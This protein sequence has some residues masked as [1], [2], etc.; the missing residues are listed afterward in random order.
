MNLIYELDNNNDINIHI[1]LSSIILAVQDS[2]VSPHALSSDI[3]LVVSPGSVLDAC[4]RSK[5]DIIPYGFNYKINNI[6]FKEIGFDIIKE[7]N[8]KTEKTN[9]NISIDFNYRDKINVLANK[10]YLLYEGDIKYF[11]GNPSKNKW[12]NENI[13]QTNTNYIEGITYIICKELGDTLQAYYAKLF[14]NENKLNNKLCLF[15]CDTVLALRCRLLKVPV[16][17]R[18]S[19][20]NS[21][22]LKYYPNKGNM[23][24]TM[25]LYECNKCINQNKSVITHINSVILLGTFY[26]NNVPYKVIDKFKLILEKIIKSIEIVNTIIDTLDTSYIDYNAYTKS[27]IQ[28]KAQHLFTLFDGKNYRLYNISALYP[29]LEKDIK[30]V[31]ILKNTGVN[32]GTIINN[33]YLPLAKQKGGVISNNITE[34]ID[35]SINYDIIEKYIISNINYLVDREYDI[36]EEKLSTILKHNIYLICKKKF[37]DMHIVD[38]YFITED[39]YNLLFYYFDYTRHVLYGL[40]FLDELIDYYETDTRLFNLLFDTFLKI[41]KEHKLIIEKKQEEEEREIARKCDELN[42]GS[43]TFEEREIQNNKINSILGKIIEIH[44]G[45]RT[46]KRILKRRSTK[47]HKRK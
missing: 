33:L 24:D 28:Y 17:V 46:R 43:T 35:T 41:F 12:F 11:E 7:L 37:K 1:I 5:D 16:I 25:K 3:K 30:K 6:N 38:Y 8:S 45:K 9:I 32:I 18:N 26:I 39:I 10:D 27:L 47:T 15:T 31:D 13:E 40:E 2:G 29:L 23:E 20:T 36:E 4:K 19:V 44:G 34:S 42:F 22:I 21:A 14:M